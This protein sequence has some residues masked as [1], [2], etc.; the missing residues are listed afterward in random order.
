[1]CASF[2]IAIKISFPILAPLNAYLTQMSSIATLLCMGEAD[3]FKLARIHS[4]TSLDTI[5]GK[6]HIL[7]FICS[8]F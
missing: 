4:L 2:T 3:R 5:V 1:M 7:R 6:V 8:S